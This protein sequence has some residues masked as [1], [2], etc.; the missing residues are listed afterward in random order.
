MVR[1]DHHEHSV[2]VI[3]VIMT[4]MIM[5][6][7][8]TVAVIVAHEHRHD[9]EHEEEHPEHAGFETLEASQRKS[10]KTDQREKRDRDGDPGVMNAPRPVRRGV[11]GGARC[12][13]V[14]VH[15]ISFPRGRSGVR[16]WCRCGPVRDMAES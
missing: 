12:F 8:V 3:A 14:A 11:G 16:L 15:A 6:M 4:V 9:A 7:I 2:P 1:P 5:V 13:D 10:F